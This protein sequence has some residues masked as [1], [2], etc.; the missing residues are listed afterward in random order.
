MLLSLIINRLVGSFVFSVGWDVGVI[1]FGSCVCGI[2]CAMV[3]L[4]KV[5]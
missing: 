2:I 5:N 4:G 1:T 3:V